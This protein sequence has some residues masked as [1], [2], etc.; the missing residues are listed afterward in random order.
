M[1][2]R[3]KKSVL[4]RLE[5]RIVHTKHCDNQ[6]VLTNTGWIKGYFPPN[7]AMEMK[8]VDEKWHYRPSDS[9]VVQTLHNYTSFWTCEHSFFDPKPILLQFTHKFN[10]CIVPYINNSDTLDKRS[11]RFDL[12]HGLWC[13]IKLSFR[14]LLR[15][16]FRNIYQQIRQ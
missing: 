3:R 5:H 1:L 9:I 7:Y 6:Y 2:W 15:Q 16:K 14:F 4:L 10:G 11:L 13:C 8:L 12:P